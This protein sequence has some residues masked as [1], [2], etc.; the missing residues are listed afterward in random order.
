[1]K[2]NGVAHMEVEINPLE[3]LNAIKNSLGLSDSNSESICVKDGFI[4]RVEDVSYHGSPVYEYKQV[5]NNPKW[6]ELYN[7]LL[8]LEN[9]FK[10]SDSEQWVK[11]LKEVNTDG[12]V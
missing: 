8:C 11:M 9:Y 6:T 1:M 5:S 2:V 4:T 10:N 3:V 7:S 12:R